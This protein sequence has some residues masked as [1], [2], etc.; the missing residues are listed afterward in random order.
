[1]RLLA[2]QF[3]H[4]WHHFVDVSYP[5]DIKFIKARYDCQ[6]QRIYRIR[7]A[8]ES[9]PHTED[10]TTITGDVGESREDLLSGGMRLPNGE[11]EFVMLGNGRPHRDRDA[12]EPLVDIK[13]KILRWMETIL[14]VSNATCRPSLPGLSTIPQVSILFDY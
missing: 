9:F 4:W 7:P 8:L 1:V 13:A 3:E 11:I 5:W 12:M 10:F 14:E 6:L 2:C